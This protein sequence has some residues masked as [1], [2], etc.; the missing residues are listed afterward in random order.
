MLEPLERRDADRLVRLL[1]RH[2][3]A[4]GSPRAAALLEDIEASLAR[5]R[6]LAPRE[7]IVE[8]EESDEGRL[9]A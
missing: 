3:R 1:E 6:R 2:Q 5:F 9:T 4:T 8:R 7:S